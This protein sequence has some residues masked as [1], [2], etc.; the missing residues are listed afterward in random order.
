MKKILAIA[1][2]LAMI[3]GAS[4]VASAEE[5]QTVTQD[6]VAQE[7][8]VTYTSAATYSITLPKTINLSQANPTMDYTITAKGNIGR[9]DVL[10][11]A[12]VDE[13]GNR[14]GINILLSD[15][16]SNN[17]KPDLVVDVIQGKTEFSSEEM[18]VTENDTQVGTSTT[19]TLTLVS[20]PEG[21]TSYSGK[22][23]F[24]IECTASADTYSEKIAMFSNLELYG[25]GD[26]VMEGYGNDYVGTMDYLEK[27]YGANVSKDYS[28]SGA[29]IKS[30]DGY[31]VVSVGQQIVQMLA[32]MNEEK[33]TNQTVLV[34]T[35]GGNDYL[36]AI[37]SAA[38]SGGDLAAASSDCIH[39]IIYP[40]MQQVYS[41]ISAMYANAGVNDFVT[42]YIIPSLKANIGSDGSS[43]F[44]FA[45]KSL[46][47]NVPDNVLVVDCTEFMTDED[48]QSDGLHW[49][50]TGYRKVSAKIAEVLYEHYN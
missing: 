40:T 1:L 31:N 41:A 19:G 5:S 13:D 32:R 23:R 17:K 37:I 6:E 34:W 48:F 28:I 45:M 14:E 29:T 30:Y 7:T 9:D 22:L 10:S 43:A 25:A 44:A 24:L 35:G 46:W 27:M 50:D 38:E 18:A 11:V 4:T 47:S 16:A 2:S 26:S 3:M 49:S 20:T 12:P 39:N 33:P 42:V 15:I 36:K 8:Q 21:G